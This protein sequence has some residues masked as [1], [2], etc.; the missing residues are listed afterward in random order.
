MAA[1]ARVSAI[2]VSRT[3]RT[4]DQVSRLTR[5]R[6]MEAVTALNYRP[7]PAAV[8]LASS[9][10]SLIGVMIPSVTNAV[11]SDVL[12]G[13]HEISDGT[14]YSVQF[15]NTRYSG[16]DEYRLLQQFLSQRPAALIVT[17]TGQS[18]EVLDLLRSASCPVVQ[19]MELGDDPV[20][21]MVG[22]S[23]SDAA[24]AGARHLLEQGYRHISYLGARQDPRSR[25][26]LDAVRSV[27]A[28]AGCLNEALM[29]SANTPA[30]VSLGAE[31]MGQLIDSGETCDAVICNNDML[32]L[33][34]LFET[35]RR[36]IDVPGAMGIC[37]F[38][39]IEMMAQTVP[40]LTSIHT[41]R[42]EVGR[43]TMEIVL[44]VIN[45]ED[46]GPKSQDLGFQLNIRE[47]TAR[48]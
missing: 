39:D 35:Q 8:A 29:I 45:G 28:E 42:L 14:Q 19:M 46:P 12:K 25:Q 1:K 20:D 31:L 36:G 18:D 13:I 24:A 23:H 43:R 30:R 32:T 10:S 41:P 11:F 9:K 38:N 27:L 47:S 6:V 40:S 4:P 5:E 15:A 2:T 33:G 22:Y 48:N 17:G 7:D 37:G 16:A 44:S 21:Y 26:R 34:A 3:L